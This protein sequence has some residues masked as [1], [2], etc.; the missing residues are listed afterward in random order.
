MEKRSKDPL[1][2]VDNDYVIVDIGDDEDN[3]KEEPTEQQRLLPLT[4]A[5]I[6][7]LTEPVEHTNVER[8]TVFFVVLVWFLLL[9]LTSHVLCHMSNGSI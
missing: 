6:R 3:P 8:C 5:Q 4:E 2:N 9:C 7:D 1:L